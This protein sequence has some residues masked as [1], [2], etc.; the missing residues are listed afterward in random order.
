MA[1]RGKL[2]AL[3]SV[4]NICHQSSLFVLEAGVVLEYIYFIMV[5]WVG[6]RGVGPEK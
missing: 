4:L 5:E 2:G 6:V 3:F 1:L